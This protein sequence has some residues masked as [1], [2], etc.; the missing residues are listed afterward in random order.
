MN[1]R[2]ASA[3]SFG[4]L[5][6]LLAPSP[7]N[8]DTEVVTTKTTTYSGVVSEINPSSSTI[9]LRSESS[10]T[11]VSYTYTKETTFVDA[12]GNVVP[13]E[14]IRNAPVRVEYSSEGGQTIV[15]RVVQTG[16]SVVVNVPAAPNVVV[17]PA[18]PNVMVAPAAPTI[19]EKTTTRTET[20]TR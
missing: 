1:K 2:I 8:A 17:A 13:Y 18:A 15:R 11:P 16:P 9:I 10:P 4:L 12:A 3:L 7:S 5:F 14:T 20:E 19:R 6:G